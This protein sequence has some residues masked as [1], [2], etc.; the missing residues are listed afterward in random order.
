MGRICR[1]AAAAASAAAAPAATPA[2]AAPAA[3]ARAAA[4]AFPGRD[5]HPGAPLT[6]SHTLTYPSSP[7]PREGPFWGVKAFRVRDPNPKL[8]TLAHTPSYPHPCIRTYGGSLL[9]RPLNLPTLPLARGPPHTHLPFSPP[10]NHLSH[11]IHA[12]ALRQP[13]G[14]REVGGGLALQGNERAGPR[15]QRY[16]HQV[17]IHTQPVPAP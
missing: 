7:A 3:A 1:T 5:P 13:A 12:Q 9:L 17:E 14:G 6:L 4:A 2:A 8:K 10:P 15:W 11:T 16:S